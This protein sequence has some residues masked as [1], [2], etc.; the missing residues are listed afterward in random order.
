MQNV[1]TKVGQSILTNS[2][3]QQENVNNTGVV[4]EVDGSNQVSD[5]SE[6]RGKLKWQ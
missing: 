4:E 1:S 2:K 3:V 5:G 6:T